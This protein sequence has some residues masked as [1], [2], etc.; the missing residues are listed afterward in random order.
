[1]LGALSGTD[2]SART[3]TLREALPSDVGAARRAGAQVSLSSLNPTQ[4]ATWRRVQMAA[5]SRA[6]LLNTDCL[7][8]NIENAPYRM[9]REGSND[10]TISPTS[11]D[12]EAFDNL[13]SIVRRA[14]PCTS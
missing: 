6:A 13:P 9:S 10:W 14:A 1:M 8:V 5:D 7:K 11:F 12:S 4:Q 2:G 3:S